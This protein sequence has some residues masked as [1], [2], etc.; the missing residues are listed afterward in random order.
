MSGTRAFLLVWAMASASVLL[1]LPGAAAPSSCVCVIIWVYELK[2]SYC[3]MRIE[4]YVPH[5]EPSGRMIEPYGAVCMKAR[6]EL[7][8]HTRAFKRMQSTSFHQ[9]IYLALITSSGITM[10]HKNQL[11]RWLKP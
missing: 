10:L 6:T 3:R 8:A 9:Y 5:D 4:P 2:K 11:L 1:Q 7:H